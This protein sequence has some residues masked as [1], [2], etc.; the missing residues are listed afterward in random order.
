[1]A[2]SM[3]TAKQ[4]ATRCTSA[5]RAGSLQ[6]VMAGQVEPQPRGTEVATH[7]DGIRNVATARESVHRCSVRNQAA[8]TAMQR[9]QTHRSRGW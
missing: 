4:T 8:V 7:V 1:M 3:A 9:A 5:F 6:S 2:T